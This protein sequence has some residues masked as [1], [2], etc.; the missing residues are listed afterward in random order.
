[1]AIY[2][3]RFKVHSRGGG[4]K[5]GQAAAY[6]SGTRVTSRTT[7]AVRAAAYRS[8][9]VLAD[10]AG[11]VHDFT[12]KQGIV[13]N[14]I[15]AP[16]NAPAWV[17]D[18]NALW[19]AV[20]KKEDTS[21]RRDTAQLF[22]EAEL[23]VPR[24]LNPTERIALVR[25]F[26]QDQF[27]AKGMVADIGIHCPKA[28][29]GGEQPHAHVMLT[30][31]ELTPEGFGYKN[32]DWNDISAG[33]KAAGEK[34]PL[35]QWREAW[36][37][38]CN[39]ALEEAGSTARVDHRT[40]AAQAQDR[41]PTPHQGQAVHVKEPTDGYAR[42]RD[43]LV[44]VNF[45]NRAREA[46]KAIGR[47]LETQTSPPSPAQA[48]DSFERAALAAGWSIARDILQGRK[49]DAAD[50]AGRFALESIRRLRIYTQRDL[51]PDPSD[52]WGADH[53]R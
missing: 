22:R 43:D 28:S 39:A 31:R 36:Q 15:L 49:H 33:R 5:A 26:V 37:T 30:M 12:R 34:S 13:W 29:D 45:E 52:L 46:V 8:G 18:R 11:D 32:R 17:F 40:L 3:C 1:M 6:R 25:A 14:A 4:A 9:G 23:T 21:T 10:A 16:D 47:K 44:R 27:V 51:S 41:E 48:S 53:E 38:Y 2:H 24:E 42:K 50:E 19:N 7:S 35:I 20:E